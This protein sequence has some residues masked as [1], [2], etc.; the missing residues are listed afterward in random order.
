MIRVELSPWRG[1]PSWEPEWNDF[2]TGS[3]E[4][5][6]LGEMPGDGFIFRYFQANVT[7]EIGGVSFSMPGIGNP[8]ID[9]VLALQTA[10]N[11]FRASGQGVADMSISPST[12]IRLKERDGLAEVSASYVKNTA[13]VSIEEFQQAV[14]VLAQKAVSLI[15]EARPEASGNIYLNSVREK[16]GFPGQGDYAP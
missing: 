2:R 11:D 1:D 7:F 5:V 3:W 6:G 9:F 16:I 14:W 15:V 12:V 13:L 8:V 4:P 10:V